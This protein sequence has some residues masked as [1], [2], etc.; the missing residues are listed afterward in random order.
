MSATS[1][2]VGVGPLVLRVQ[3]EGQFQPNDVASKIKNM[4]YTEDGVLRSVWGPTAYVPVKTALGVLG[5]EDPGNRPTSRGFPVVGTWG[6]SA[7][8]VAGTDPDVPHYG[9]RQHGI[10]HA[11]M[12]ETGRD[13]LL[14]HTGNELW[15]KRGWQRNWRRVLSPT[16]GA[17]GLTA[18]L[19]DR[20]TPDF[21]TQFVFTGNGVVI[22][23]QDYRA[24][25]Y[26]GAYIAPLG[27]S[28]TPSAPQGR[29]P[30]SSGNALGA[31]LRGIN[32]IGYAHIG[33]HIGSMLDDYTPTP[34][35]GAVRKTSDAPMTDGFGDCRIGTVTVMPIS[36]PDNLEVAVSGWL[37]SGEW[38]CAVQFIDRWGNLSPLSAQSNPISCDV[39]PAVIVTNPGS[40]GG[41][42]RAK[43]TKMRFQARW[44]GISPGPDHTIGRRLYRTKD[45]RSTGDSTL[46][47]LPINALAT[48]QDF[49]TLPDNVCTAYPDNIPDAWLGSPATTVLPVPRFRLATMAMGRLWI[50]NL[51]GALSTLRPS[52]PGFWGTFEAGHDLAP[53]PT[54]E[55]TGLFAVPGGLLAFTR[56]STFLITPSDDGQ[57]FVHA[58]VSRTVG[59]EA[60]SSVAATPD[61]L[62]VWLGR[63]GFYAYDGEGVTYASP[64]LRRQFREVTVSRLCQAVAAVDPRSREYRCWVSTLGSD[65]NNHCFIF[66]GQGWRERTDVEADS[67][68]VTTDHRQY[69]LVGGKIAGDDLRSGVFLLDHDASPDVPAVVADR[70]A[71]VET[72]WIEAGDSK[73]QKSH[74]RVS[75][76]LRE[77][78][79][80]TLTVEVMKNWR[81]AVVHTATAN[82][83]SEK[84]VPAIWQS[85]VSGNAVWTD[86]RPFWRRVSI[87]VPSADTVKF[88]IRGTGLWEFVGLEVDMADRSFGGAQNTP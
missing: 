76:W 61:G 67:V 3:S 85:A 39:H 36:D 22:I 18:D 58:P 14:L 26:D 16:P 44:E 48:S 54:G 87:Y 1:T 86:R 80:D 21:P 63:D 50:G 12:P 79:L 10:F 31:N 84:D 6:G 51:D 72:G 20:Q 64:Q 47:S 45:I 81:Q 62:V 27:F 19:P 68:C 56:S 32:D 25:F 28:E 77:T 8:A 7:V 75:L 30:Q 15:E 69:M 29:G 82:R 88:R 5:D 42:V 33:S 66:D 83:Y 70:E 13:L 24:Y 49:A 35:A 37:N 23:P 17:H 52:Q 71:V 43:V 65:T 4:F 74:Y 55:L 60:P 11:R 2:S 40:T 53:D 59:C 57:G 41:N 34:Y 46:Y 9:F 73:R 78:D 38:R